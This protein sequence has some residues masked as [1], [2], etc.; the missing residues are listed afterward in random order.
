M[1]DIPTLGPTMREGDL[2]YALLA[3]S[4]KLNERRKHEL[5]RDR[6]VMEARRHVSG[7]QDLRLGK[8][9]DAAIVWHRD[10]LPLDPR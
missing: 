2:L 8:I 10:A 4:P 5:M 9:S 1:N 6:V 7:L 3:R